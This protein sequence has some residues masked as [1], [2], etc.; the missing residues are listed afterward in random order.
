MPQITSPARSRRCRS[1]SMARLA[2]PGHHPQQKTPGIS[3][4]SVL[5]LPMWPTPNTNLLRQYKKPE[6]MAVAGLKSP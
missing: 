1:R 6:I 4:G 5:P 3:A 2:G